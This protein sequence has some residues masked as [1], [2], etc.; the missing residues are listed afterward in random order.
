[1]A[2]KDVGSCV[3]Q[4]R[5]QLVNLKEETKA[6]EEKVE[7]LLS[8]QLHIREEGNQPVQDVLKSYK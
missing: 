2:E 5:I 3:E 4:N 6:L 7:E 8:K 1:M